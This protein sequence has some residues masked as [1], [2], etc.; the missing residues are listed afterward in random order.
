VTPAEVVLGILA[1]LA[2]GIFSGLFGVG[3]GTVATPAISILLG[4]PPIVAVATPL[5][6]IF[7]TAIVGAAT[8]ARAGEIDLR[9]AVWMSVTGT[10]A[11]VAGALVAEVVEGRLLL[12][13]TAILLAREAI[14]VARN[15]N[16][17]RSAGRRVSLW[18]YAAIG[19]LAGFASGLLGIGGGLVMVPLLAGV[20]GMPLKRA[21][22]TS[23]AAIVALVIP[24]TIA[25]AALGNIDWSIFALLAIGSVIGARIG[26]TIALGAKEGTLRLAVGA[27]LGVVAVV[28]GGS[29]LINLLRTT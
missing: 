22:G 28:Y 26:A 7:P 10:V 18:V 3:G 25:H 9:A 4:A 5:P 17:E 27:F 13:V 19:V 14:Q 29:E 21:L 24:G 12:V 8:Y 2:A 20:L 16:V 23:L 1:G 11:A 15:K 6:V